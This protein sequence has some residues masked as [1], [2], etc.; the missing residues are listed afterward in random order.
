LSFGAFSVFS[1][2]ISRRYS[3]STAAFR[4]LRSVMIW[5][6][7]ARE[8]VPVRSRLSRSAAM[9]L[10]SSVAIRA[11][12]RCAFHRLSACRSFSSVPGFPW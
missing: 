8:R 9:S 10:A 5:R 7:T 3:S 12:P 11:S 2:G 1:L 6:L 4:T